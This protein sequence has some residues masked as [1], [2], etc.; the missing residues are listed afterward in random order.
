MTLAMGSVKRV[1]KVHSSTVTG[2]LPAEDTACE[3]NATG[4][5]TAVHCLHS[6]QSTHS[7][8]EGSKR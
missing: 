5:C 7:A 8:A 2:V 1:Y 3:N 6:M 4:Q